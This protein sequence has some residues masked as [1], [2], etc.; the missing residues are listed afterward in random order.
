MRALPL[1]V[2]SVRRS[3]ASA[4]VVAGLAA[5]GAHLLARL[6]KQLRGFV[7]ED[8]QHLRVDVVADVRERI[9]HRR[10]AARRRFGS[11][12]R[13][14][15]RDG[16]GRRGDARRGGRAV[17]AA[18]CRRL[19]RRRRTP[20]RRRRRSSSSRATSSAAASAS[21]AS[22]AASWRSSSSSRWIA[23]ASSTSPCVNGCLRLDARH[24]HG[25]DPR[26][27]ARAPDARCRG[28]GAPCCSSAISVCS[29]AFAV[30]ATSGNPPVRWM[31]HSVWLARTIAGARHRARIELQDGQLVLERG[32]VLVGLVAQDRPQRSRR[33]SRRRS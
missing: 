17:A 22:A 18:G 32:E 7:E 8:R 16:V 25:A 33:A 3:C 10:R 21:P 5:P 1:N 23:S 30:V 11:V 29:S 26:S 6:R 15:P 20:A 27:R 31:P 28:S 9:G 14:T 19:A 24:E 2:C 4:R 12:V 13:A